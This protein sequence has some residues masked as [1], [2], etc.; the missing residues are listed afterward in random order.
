MDWQ[1]IE[2]A[3][4]DGRACWLAI[5]PFNMHLLPKDFSK[6]KHHV[7]LARYDTWQGYWRQA[8]T[9]EGLIGPGYLTPDFWQLCIVPAAPDMKETT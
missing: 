5:K 3:P 2:T 8:A 4:K 9:G 6:L 7:I 1:P